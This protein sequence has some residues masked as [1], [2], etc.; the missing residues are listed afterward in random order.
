MRD[1]LDRTGSLLQAD[2]V[3]GIEREFGPEFIY[4]NE[5]G[6]PAIDKRVLREFREL[7]ES[8]VVWDR[9]AF[10]WRDRTPDDAPGRKQDW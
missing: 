2:A 8:N 9:W 10:E 4:K 1:E 7:T 6:D 3:A 5:S